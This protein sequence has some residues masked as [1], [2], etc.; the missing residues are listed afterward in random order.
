VLDI[1]R[2]LMDEQYD[3]VVCLD[4]LHRL[5]NPLSALEKL[6]DL[7][8]K[9]LIVEITLRSSTNSSAN[10]L[11]NLV[12]RIFAVFPAIFVGGWK[13]RDWDAADRFFVTRRAFHTL[14]TR[15]RFSIAK[16]DFLPIGV[17][18]FI[19]VARKRQIK[20]L[21][22]VAGVPTS[23]KST[24][25]SRLLAGNAPE[26]ARRLQMKTTEQW[27]SVGYGDV[28]HITEPI[29]GN[30]ILHFNITT[31]VLDSDYLGYDGGL[32]DLIRAAERFSAITLWCP[33]LQLSQRYRA[34]RVKAAR[35]H[36]KRVRQNRK[37]A[38][39]LSLYDQ[40]D[41][42][43]H[44]FAQ[45]FAFLSQHCPDVAILESEGVDR[46]ITVAEWNNEN[47]GRPKRGIGA[48]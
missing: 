42:L 25:I 1:E 15:H 26:V 4:R 34:Y 24:L 11:S 46:I 2:D 19:A 21:I 38:K 10:R 32:L 23:G 12:R 17:G 22:I 8:R 37:H 7:T 33:P 27:V 44:L 20:N 31:P 16:T 45:W 41:A 30:M 35:F 28:P 3:F 39:L 14:V 43:M 48:A 5:R 18:R 47:W 29:V 36:R 40:P 13:R 9:V 6:I